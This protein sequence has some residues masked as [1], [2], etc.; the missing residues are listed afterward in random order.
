LRHHRTKNDKIANAHTLG[1][2][3]ARRLDCV[4]NPMTLQVTLWGQP[5]MRA[6]D[7]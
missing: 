1:H 3:R 6:D 7:F 5:Y 4:L 2:I